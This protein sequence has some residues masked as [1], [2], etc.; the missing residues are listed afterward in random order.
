MVNNLTANNT[1]YGV[2]FAKSVVG[3]VPVAGPFF[4]ELVGLIP[5]QRADRVVAYV[6]ALGVRVHQLEELVDLAKLD[7]ARERV[8]LFELGGQAAQG[9]TSDER[10]DRIVHIVAEGLSADEKT[11]LDQAR[12]L[13]LLSS[14]DDYKLA[15]LVDFAINSGDLDF[16]YEKR[17]KGDFSLSSSTSDDSEEQIE[18]ETVRR[19]AFRRLSQLDLVVRDSNRISID[20]LESREPNLYRMSR[21][22]KYF[23]KAIGVNRD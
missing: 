15:L 11:A 5:G 23:L 13:R 3:V 12:V 17:P 16:S 6:R 21:E 4:S 9:A 19:L 20:D 8:R 14:I 22:G 2:A 7:K 18:Q 1:D 10:I